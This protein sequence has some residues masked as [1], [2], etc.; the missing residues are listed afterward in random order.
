[1]YDVFLPEG[2]TFEDNNEYYYNSRGRDETSEINKRYYIQIQSNIIILENQA[3]MFPMPLW[4]S[5]TT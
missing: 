2:W 5:Q 1:M 4:N 3:L